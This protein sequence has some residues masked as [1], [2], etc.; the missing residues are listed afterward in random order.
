MGKLKWKQT[1]R[2]SA[3]TARMQA[4]NSALAAADAGVLSDRDL[5][6]TASRI[7]ML[8]NVNLRNRQKKILQP[9]TMRAEAAR[10]KV[11]IA[12]GDGGASSA[13][14]RGASTAARARA[15]AA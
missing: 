5:I 1:S 15:A 8:A 7:V 3:G 6:E 4:A 13:K 2:W 12:A 11:V 9:R 10:I 14:I